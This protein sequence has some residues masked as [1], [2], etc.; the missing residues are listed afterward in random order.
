MKV[1]KRNWLVRWA[2]LGERLGGDSP[3]DRTNICELFVRIIYLA[4]V[5]CFMWLIVGIIVGPFFLLGW[6][7]SSQRRWVRGSKSL[8]QLV[9]EKWKSSLIYQR[10][11]DFKN[12]TCTVV[13][14]E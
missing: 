8:D 4:P 11:V 3:P 5:M 10:I 12:R 7:F 1:S 9:S 6:I 14:L 2:F 13:D